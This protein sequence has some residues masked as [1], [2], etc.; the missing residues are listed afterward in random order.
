M[1]AHRLR[2][3]ADRCPSSLFS[4]VMATGIVGIAAGQAGLPAIAVAL[5]WLAA[6]ALAACWSLLAL[7]LICAR[8]AL[9]AGFADPVRA[10]GHL[11]AVAATA[12]VGSGAALSGGATASLVLLAIAACAWLV[13]SCAILGGVATA[14]VKPAPATGLHAGWLLAVVATQSLGV[15]ATSVAPTLA[16]GARDL[17]DAGALCSWLV[18]LALY[19]A[20]AT[21]LLGRA[22]FLPFTPADLAPTWWITMGAMA[23]STVAGAQLV[24]AADGGLLAGMLPAL[25][26]GSVL[27]WALGTWWLPL[28]LVLHA[29]LH[30]WRGV[31]LRYDFGQWSAVFPLGMYSVA[32]A[33][34][35]KAVHVP[36]LV[37]LGSAFA[38]IALAAWLATTAGWLRRVAGAP[39]ALRAD[40]PRGH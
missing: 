38:W 27:C 29:W 32:S 35:G 8:R 36:A 33:T 18:G 6:A 39:A 11:T 24:L 7:R 37:A 12:V 14:S 19:G 25:R 23:I 26:A 4:P 10:P 3:V 22:L 2:S 5:Q 40:L 13:L 9:L 34:L 17:L 31:P 15:L 28:L 20:I 30:G 16:P 21:L 1:Q